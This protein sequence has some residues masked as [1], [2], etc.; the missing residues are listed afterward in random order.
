VASLKNVT[1]LEILR[2]NMF[3]CDTIPGN[4]EFREDYICGSEDL[5]EALYVFGVA[6][7]VVGGFGI[8][9][10]I[11]L[12]SSGVVD[13]ADSR[14]VKWRQYFTSPSEAYSPGI[15]Q[16]RTES[17]VRK[18]RKAMM[19]FLQLLLLMLLAVSPVYSARGSDP[20][21]STHASTYAWFWS[22]A[23][24]RGVLPSALIALAWCLLITLCY[25]HMIAASFPGTHHSDDEGDAQVKCR[26]DNFEL[27]GENGIPSIAEIARLPSY[28]Y[29]RKIVSM[30]VNAAVAVTI[31]ALYIYSMQQPLSGLVH[32]SIQF[33]LALFRMLYNFWVLPVL[34]RSYSDPIASV[35]MR[36]RLL[37]VNNLVIPCVVTAFTSPECFQVKR[38]RTA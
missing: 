2:G 10:A 18:L 30:L 11:A 38:M 13:A 7:L 19:L 12:V 1:K 28:S 3:S 34:T 4:D 33:S 36:L 32:F 27:P 9:V 22:L 24:M 21:H 26:N 31:N 23:Y 29:P 17:L 5:N 37:T 8:A 16:Q 15:T 35:L 20:V 25:Y 6:F 14:L